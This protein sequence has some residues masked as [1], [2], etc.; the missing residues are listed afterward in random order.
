MEQPSAEPRNTGEAKTLT[1]I[2]TMMQVKVS[3]LRTYHH[4]LLET[5]RKSY[6]EF[7]S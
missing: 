5:R 3:R 7:Y 2:M 1:Q 6:R 4:S